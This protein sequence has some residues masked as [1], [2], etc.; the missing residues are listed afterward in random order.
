M[1]VADNPL[2]HVVPGCIISIAPELMNLIISAVSKM[3]FPSAIRA[4]EIDFFNLIRPSRSK[5]S[6]GS[7]IHSNPISLSEVTTS[8]VNCKSR[9]PKQYIAIPVFSPSSLFSLLTVLEIIAIPCLP[10][11]GP[12]S[13]GICRYYKLVVPCSRNSQYV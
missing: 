11:S 5:G 6:R 12:V 13:A 4:H 10:Y 8:M 1:T 3:K 7:S 2:L 9:E